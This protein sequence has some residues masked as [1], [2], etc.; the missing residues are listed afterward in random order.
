MIGVLKSL[1]CPPAGTGQVV[2]QEAERQ[3]EAHL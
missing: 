1:G 3:R 2:L